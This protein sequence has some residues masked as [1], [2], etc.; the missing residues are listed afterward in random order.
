M[1]Y[2]AL[3][4]IKNIFPSFFLFIVCICQHATGYTARSSDPDKA[5]VKESD[6]SSNSSSDSGSNSNDSSDDNVEEDDSSVA[7]E[8][9]D[10]HESTGTETPFVPGLLDDRIHIS[11]NGKIRKAPQISKLKPDPKQKMR[12]KLMYLSSSNLHNK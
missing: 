7:E 5:I 11:S 10:D 6:N 4:F 12:G 8:D 2:T 1:Y 9:A 3:I